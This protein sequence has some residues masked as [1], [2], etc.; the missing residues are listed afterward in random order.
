MSLIHYLIGG[1]VVAA[2][3]AAYQL[4]QNAKAV[5]VAGVVTQLKS[6]V[7]NLK[8][9]LPTLKADAAKDAAAVKSDIAKI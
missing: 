4:Y 7:A 6:D 3:A 9:A 5:T 1:G 8:A 2:G